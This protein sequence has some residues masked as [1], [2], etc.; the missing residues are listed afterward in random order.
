MLGGGGGG[1][2]HA[3]KT[4]KKKGERVSKW[5]SMSEKHQNVQ[6]MEKVN[7][8]TECALQFQSQIAGGRLPPDLE[9]D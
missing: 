7:G 3:V 6:Q 5:S 1:R 9:A 2:E 8:L 4:K